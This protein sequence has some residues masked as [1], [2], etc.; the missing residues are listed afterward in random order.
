[1]EALPSFQEFSQQNPNAN[2]HDYGEAL[3]NYR[4]ETAAK[5]GVSVVELHQLGP[6]IACKKI[7]ELSN[8]GVYAQ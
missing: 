2:L 5:I 7:E 8:N 3:E 1:M 6:E 4:I